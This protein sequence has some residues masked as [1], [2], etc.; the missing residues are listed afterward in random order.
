MKSTTRNVLNKN[1]PGYASMTSDYSNQL[2][3]LQ[4]IADAT[5]VGSKAKAETV[6]T[7]IMA[8]L[9]K[10]KGNRLNALNQLG[11]NLPEMIAGYKAA[12]LLPGGLA[13][14]MA[15]G[16]AIGLLLHPAAA[17]PLAGTML[18]SSP[19]LIGLLAKATGLSERGANSLIQTL[20]KKTGLSPSQL[21]MML[22]QA[23]RASQLGQ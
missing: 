14:K 2:N 20:S 1:V 16:E 17:V 12:K 4:E 21:A 18:G 11:G 22:T 19:K 5:G 7:K 10:G 3:Q 8:S 13:E 15:Q 6:M 23:N 9:N